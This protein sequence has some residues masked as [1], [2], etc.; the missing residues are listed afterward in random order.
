MGQALDRRVLATNFNPLP[1]LQL[2]LTLSPPEPRTLD[3]TVSR[4]A[5]TPKAEE[6]L[7]RHLDDLYLVYCPACTRPVS[8]DYIIWEADRP[9]EKGFD[10]P[11]CDE[12]GVAPITLQDLDMQ[13]GTVAQEVTY[14]R[15]YQRLADKE[16]PRGFRSRV[17][18]LL[19][20]YTARNRYALS[21]L[22][23]HA[24]MLFADDEASLQIIRGL[25]L[26]CLQ[27]CHS[28]HTSPEQLELPR[29][30]QRPRRL[31][32]RNVWRT[33]EAAYRQQGIGSRLMEL[34]QGKAQDNGYRMLSLIAFQDNLPALALYEKHGFQVV[35][36]VRLAPNAF[37]P[38]S[39]GCWLLTAEMAV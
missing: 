8:A 10:C 34:T 4:L 20:L 15:L 17:Q 13:A 25:C 12:A 36:D 11:H 22:I 32:E 16:A 7:S 14:W 30:L 2:R 18:R 33:F 21:E 37:I 9:V 27:R 31:V 29:S 3:A 1:L 39:D 35:A 23:L 28:L 6:V 24:E 38:H 26:A 5:D 19:N